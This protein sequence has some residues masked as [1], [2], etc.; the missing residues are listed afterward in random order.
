MTAPLSKITGV[1]GWESEDEQE[2]LVE[3]ASQV[4]YGGLIVEIGSEYGMSASLFIHGSDK[5]VR[6]LCIDIMEDWTEFRTNLTNAGLYDESRLHILRAN[7]HTVEWA[8]TL[9]RDMPIDLLFIDGDHSYAGC[10]ADIANF[11]P[12]VKVGGVVA[13]HDTAAITNNHPHPLHH[14]VSKA[15]SEWQESDDGPKFKF[16]KSVDSISIFERIE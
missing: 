15:I 11:C 16:A 1:P 13:F 10:A 2:C 9:E 7:S 8:R 14:E 12:H 4:P 6:L 5:S 3:L